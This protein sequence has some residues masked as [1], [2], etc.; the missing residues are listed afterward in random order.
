MLQRIQ[1][2]LLA[3]VPVLVLILL[4]VPVYSITGKLPET[5]SKLTLLSGTIALLLNLLP[6]ALA[7]FIIFR[8][9]NRPQQIKLCMAGVLL[10]AAVLAVMLLIPSTLFPA[11]KAADAVVSFS[12]GI[13]ILPVNVLLFFLASRYI[14]RDED[15]VRSADRL[16]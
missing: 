13:F 3:G 5:S 2:L 10:S 1:S 8:Y 14:R 4:F 11:M 7:V 6:A 9:S 16:R 15:L 12:A